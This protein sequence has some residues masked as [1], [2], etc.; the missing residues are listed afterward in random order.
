MSDGANVAESEESASNEGGP[1]VVLLDPCVEPELLRSIEAEL[2]RSI[3]I[4]EP[5]PL[6]PDLPGPGDLAVI[7][8]LDLGAVSGIDL[9]ES[10]RARAESDGVP[11][12]VTSAEPTRRRVRAALR[13]GAT[14]WLRQPYEPDDWK[15][16]LGPILEAAGQGRD[17]AADRTEAEA[18]GP[19][20]A[21][22]A[23]EE[24]SA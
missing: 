20:Q 24:A 10:L 16:R 8:P 6:D 15:K 21:A 3:R 2:G 9:V 17:P 7:V 22:D 13:A 14:T 19:V 1:A 12:A 18:E 5:L 11:I 23:R 4:V